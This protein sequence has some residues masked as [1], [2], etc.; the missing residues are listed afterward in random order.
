MNKLNYLPPTKAFRNRLLLVAGASLLSTTQLFAADNEKDVAKKDEKKIVITGSRISR[1]EADGPAPVRVITAEDIKAQG[2]ETIFDALNNL[3]W[4]TGGIQGEQDANSFT[5][6]AQGLNLRGFGAG[7]TLT[8]INGRR[9]ADYPLP[10]N[11]QSNFTNLG[12]IPAAAVARIE[13]LSSGASAIYGSDAIAGV[14][15]IILKKDLDYTEI[16]YTHGETTE[17]L[18]NSGDSELFTV[19]TGWFNDKWSVTAGLEYRHTSP[20]NGFD[21]TYL[22]S[23]DD[24]PDV[25]P[26]GSLGFGAFNLDFNTFELTTPFNCE[27]ID[28]ME[29]Q[30]HRLGSYC[31]YNDV[32]ENTIRN[33][34]EK[35]STFTSVSYELS[36]NMELFADVLI[37]NQTAKSNI[38]KMFYQPNN[39][40]TPGT[41][42]G[43]ANLVLRVFNNTETGDQSARY[44]E[45]AWTIAF[46][47]K[48]TLFDE[49]DYEVSYSKNEYDFESKSFGFLNASIAALIP[50]I[51]DLFGAFEPSD[52]EG[53]IKD[54]VRGGTSS[55]ET[56]NFTITGDIAETG[57]GEISYAAVVEY[58]SQDYLLSA[59]QDV[60]DG[61]FTNGSYLQGG[62]DRDRAAIG[63]ELAIPLLS[64]SAIG[65]LEAQIAGRFD[66]YIDDSPTGG[67]F[68]YTASLMWR[69][70]DSLLIRGGR[71]TSFRAPDMHYLF[72]GDSTFFDNTNVD[73]FRCRTENDGVDY[74]DNCIAYSESVGGVRNGNLELKEEEGTTASLGIVWEPTEGLSLSLDIYDLELTNIVQDLSTTRLMSDEANCRIGT[75]PSGSINFDINSALC[76]DVL[77]RITRFTDPNDQFFGEVDSIRISPVNRA[78]RSQRGADFAANYT[79]ETVDLGQFYARIDYTYIDSIKQQQEADDEPIEIRDV[80]DVDNAVNLKN[81]MNVTLSWRMDDYS[82]SIFWNRIGGLPIQQGD[83]FQGSEDEF[84]ATYCDTHGRLDAWEIT[85]LVLSYQATDALSFRVNVNNLFNK[86]PIHDPT[87][88]QW[89]WYQSSHYNP[90]GR[91]IFVNAT[92]RI[93]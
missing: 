32:G 15:N 50:T 10:L 83:C 18:G 60:I 30:Q 1:A 71:A 31:G 47:I 84:F 68:T 88:G 7:R 44:D 22:D 58:S 20:I 8:L 45:D 11:G 14:I 69:P 86:E 67:A 65:D 56:L 26:G 34:R 74:P 73:I 91:E 85:N 12:V 53:I 27:Q 64:D 77:S 13:I 35:L 81:K 49:H 41:E 40:R 92:Y 75:N 55:I 79:W 57:A 21:R 36:D 5:P 17:G 59:N 16:S 25:D 70:T 52:F 63:V 24:E 29:L 93:D 89:P 46:G 42:G 9:L 80:V 66:N 90:I 62:G 87:L 23:N 2:H 4:N 48:G 76:M 39:L 43:R 61:N 19:A 38:F 78:L 3:A 28:W 72:A 82:A 51:D 6:N 33:R 37:F 54:R